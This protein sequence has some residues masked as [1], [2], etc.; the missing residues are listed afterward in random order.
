MWTSKYA[1]FNVQVISRV[2]GVD[3]WNERFAILY[4]ENCFITDLN[5]DGVFLDYQG[6]RTLESEALVAPDV[7]RDLIL[8]KP[9][10]RVQKYIRY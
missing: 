4:S 5:E 2:E 8:A 1:D 7:I 9:S 10:T 6:L 3:I